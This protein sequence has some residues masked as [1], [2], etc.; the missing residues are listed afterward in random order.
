MSKPGTAAIIVA[1]GRGSRMGGDLPK[2]YQRLGARTV[3][4]H[5]LA[6]FAAH[7]RIGTVQAVIHADDAQRYARASAGIAGLRA[8][9]PGGDSRQGSVLAG[10]EALAAEPPAHVLIHDAARPFVDAG[11]IERV[12]AAL[13]DH[14]GAVPAVAVSDTLKRADNGRI[15]GTVAR[16]GLWAAQTPQGFHY[17]RI[18]EAHR[19]AA[20]AGRD[21]F[22]DD[23][24]VAEWA[25]LDVALVEGSAANRKITTAEDLMEARVRMLADV[26]I[27]QGYDV[28]AFAPGRALV[29]GGIEIDHE[30]GL[31]GHSDADVALHAL[32]DALLGALGDGDIGSH[33]PPSDPKWRDAAS[34]LFLSDAARRV[35]ERGGTIGH[36]D[37]TIICEAPKIGPHRERMRARISEILEIEP[38]RI[39]IK[40]TTTEGLGFTGR[41]EGIAAQAVATIR[42]PMADA[43]A[44]GDEAHG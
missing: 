31:K 1:A 33:F 32:T 42:L 19:A 20:D 6:A 43:A 11:T 4:G 25:G 16:S 28:H 44:N 38:G 39:S 35:A 12:C 10:L 15:A 29:L 3:L 34:H 13:P 26:R 24:A 40:A 5:T 9:V 18:C 23:A 2:Q 7:P 21:D 8:P 27:G 37:L 14:H 22:T 41:R 17:D 30:M 36:L